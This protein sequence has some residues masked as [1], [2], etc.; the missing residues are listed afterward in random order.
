MHSEFIFVY[1]GKVRIE[2]HSFVGGF[3]VMPPFVGKVGVPPLSALGT[4]IGIIRFTRWVNC[5]VWKGALKKSL[6]RR[7]WTH[8]EIFICLSQAG[9]C[10][11]GC[12][13]GTYIYIW[14]LVFFRFI[15]LLERRGQGARGRWRGKERISSRLP[16]E[17]RACCVTCLAYFL[18]NVSAFLKISVIL[19]V[20]CLGLWYPMPGTIPFKECT[21]P[22]GSQALCSSFDGNFQ[23]ICGNFV[24]FGWE[25][26]GRY[27][28]LKLGFTTSALEDFKD[29]P[30]YYWCV[31]ATEDADYDTSCVVWRHDCALGVPESYKITIQTYELLVLLPSPLHQRGSWGSGKWSSLSEVRN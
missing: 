15:Y 6:F 20:V 16:T 26:R 14:L 8:I 27:G 22:R 7:T 31:L 23:R 10:A 28:T 3:L 21:V 17:R 13:L 30:Q 2:L 19:I 4:I 12:M 5:W 11:V 29:P 25:A 9:S 24:S 18:L 1:D